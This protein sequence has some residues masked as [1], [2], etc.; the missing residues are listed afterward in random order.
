MQKTF[1]L[2]ALIFVGGLVSAQVINTEKKRLNSSEEGWEGSW[3]VGFSLIK[4]TREILQFTNRINV[5]YRENN[6]TLLLLNDANIMRVNR[7]Q[8]L[9]RGFLH[10]RY[11]Y[12]VNRALIPEVFVQAQYNQIWK[13]D[14]R[15]LTGAGPRFRL[16][17]NDTSSLY[18]GALL[19]YE[20]EQITDGIEYNR[21]MRFSAYISGHYQFNPWVQ[22]DHITY[23]QPKVNDFFDY[24]VSTETSLRFGITSRL[25]FKTMFSLSYDARPPDDLQN[26]FYSWVNGLSLTF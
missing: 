17:A 20:Y 3:D 14:L 23:F 10:A 18:M 26:T 15:F 25:G 4:N 19:M 6:H 1:I 2:L 5:Q 12:E 16:L 24:R 22:L 21:D 8:L 7:D 9:N 11:N 13:I